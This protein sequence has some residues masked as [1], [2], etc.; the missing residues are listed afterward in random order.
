LFR[1]GKIGLKWG[2]MK[3]LVFL[4]LKGIL[5]GSGVGLCLA[6]AVGLLYHSTHGPKPQALFGGPSLYFLVV[7]GVLGNLG[8][9]CLALQMIL[10]NLLTSLFMKISELVPAPASVVGEEWAKKMEGFFHQILEPMPVL[11]RKF[12]EFF[13]VTRFEDY[14]RINRALDKAKKNE[15]SGKFTS[16]WMSMVLLHYFLEPLWLFFYAVYVILFLISCILWSFPFF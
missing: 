5:L 4:F 12:V 7:G 14:G 1:A 8:G 9:W 13:L 16:Q 10:L 6:G 11:F 2:H 15:P 3:N